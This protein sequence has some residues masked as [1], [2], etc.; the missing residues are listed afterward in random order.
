MLQTLSY[1]CISSDMV[2]CQFEYRFRHC[3]NGKNQ[4][5][6]NSF[7]AH[8]YPVKVGV[9]WVHT[10]SYVQCEV[11]RVSSPTVGFW[12]AWWRSNTWHKKAVHQSIGSTQNLSPLT[13]RWHGT[14]CI[15]LLGRR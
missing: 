15:L 4:R 2:G 11:R 1:A 3:Q 14:M 10:S 13:M 7:S 5:G 6:D 8:C 12:E 9:L